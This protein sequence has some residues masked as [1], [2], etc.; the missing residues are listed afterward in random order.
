MGPITNEKWVLYFERAPALPLLGLTMTN[1]II[2][3]FIYSQI[4]QMC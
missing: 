2:F 1:V 4:L 3:T